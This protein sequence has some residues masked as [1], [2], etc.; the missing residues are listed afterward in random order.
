MA[1]RLAGCGYV[2]AAPEIFHRR[3]PIG[4]VIK[5]DAMG[6]L[7]GN[8]NVRNTPT[9]AQATACIYPTGLQDG[10]LGSDRADSLQRAA[11][12]QGALLTI[13]GSLD[14]HVPEPARESILAE[15][16]AVPGLRQRSRL[17]KANH[18]FMR[19]DGE[20]WDPQCSDQAWWEVIAFLQKELG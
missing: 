9:A 8:N 7:R 1:D 17:Y 2:A 4:A 10:V 16:A 11:E 12:I 13:F 15:L 14:P 5:P 20:R 18:T 3:E 6:R 19:D